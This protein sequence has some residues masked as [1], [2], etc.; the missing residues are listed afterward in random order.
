MPNSCELNSTD[1]EFGKAAYNY[2]EDQERESMKKA[3]ES[4]TPLVESDDKRR[5]VK[6]NVIHRWPNGIV[7]YTLR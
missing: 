5:T 4:E 3:F 2:T 6:N 7:P 1:L